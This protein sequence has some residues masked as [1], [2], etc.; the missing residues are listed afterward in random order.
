MLVYLALNEQRAYS[1]YSLN[2]KRRPYFNAGY[3][4]IDDVQSEYADGID[5]LL[6]AASSPSVV[7]TGG[8]RGKKKLPVTN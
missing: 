7:V 8:W 2:A 3:L 1:H 5:P 4:V 6:V